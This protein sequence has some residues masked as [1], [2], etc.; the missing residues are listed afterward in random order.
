MRGVGGWVVWP[1][2]FESVWEGGGGWEE[3]EDEEEEE[4]E[5]GWVGG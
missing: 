5:G 3:E 1:L 4:E 2:S